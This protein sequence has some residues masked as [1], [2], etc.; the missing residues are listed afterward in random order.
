M[1]VTACLGMTAGITNPPVALFHAALEV[2]QNCDLFITLLPAQ[3]ACRATWHVIFKITG[4]DVSKKGREICRS[5]DFNSE[6][7]IQRDGWL[8]RF[9]ALEAL[10]RFARKAPA[11]HVKQVLPSSLDPGGPQT[12]NED[13]QIF[14]APVFIYRW[15]LVH[16]IRNKLSKCCLIPKCDI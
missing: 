5:L 4:F 1:E 7:S 8:A 12:L 11:P 14:K 15:L 13:M 3:K 9:A 2:S 10:Q 6:F 16:S